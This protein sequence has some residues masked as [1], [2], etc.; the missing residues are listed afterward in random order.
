MKYIIKITLGL[1]L[2]AGVVTSCKD[3]DEP[4]IDGITVDKEEITIG[5]EG[6]TEKIAV[7]SN[8]QWVTRA[9]EPWIAI[10][11]ANGIGSAVC[12]LAI[13]STL[14]N[15]ARTAQIRFSADGRESKLVTVTQFGF[16]KQIL[17]REPEVKILSSDTYNKRHFEAII[18]TNVEFVIEEKDVEYSFAEEATMTDEE[19]EEVK[20]ECSGW[21]TLPKGKDLEVDLDRGARP[22]TIKVDF[23]WGMNVAPYTRVAKIHLVPKYPEKDQ[24][25]DSDGN[26]IDA[27]VLTVTQEKAMKIEDNR[28]GDSLA[29]ITINSKLQSMM[30]FDTSESMLNWDFVT[31]W[32][33]T[34][35]EI[36]SGELPA[37]AIGRVR[38]VSYAMIDLQ[39]GESL[40]REIRHLKYLESFTVQS[41]GN[42]QIRTISL[43]EEICGLEYLKNLTIFSVGINALPE[44]FA[45]LGKKLENLNLAN[46]NFQTLSVVTK[47]VNEDNF[48]KLRYL[49]LTG[50]RATD[51]LRDL[52]LVD[53]NNKYNGRDV[54]LHVD[55]SQ[56]QEERTALLKLLTWDKLISLELAYNFI[57]GELPTDAEMTAALADAG[58]PVSYQNTDFFSEEDLTTTPSIYLDKISSDTCQWLLTADNPVTYL[59]QSPIRGQDVPRVLP[60]AREVRLNLNFLTG[61]IP[62]WILFH[63]YFAYW[64]PIT[65]VFNQQE[66]GKN[67]AGK[68]VGFD[69]VDLVN[70]DYSYYYGKK[71]PG[72]DQVVNGVAYPLYYRK[73]VL[74][75]TID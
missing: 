36:K 26:K 7:S 71:D 27:V 62:N 2:C 41:N 72:T 6:G 42:S 29:I 8:V 22:R 69:N 11:P 66:G 43:G 30:S 33:S 10:S 46:N 44:N 56:G 53:G 58:K 37:E 48:P 59:N 63:P 9:S 1:V 31:L 35:K 55:I 19:M 39:D 32:E 74:S 75:E 5:A 12:D 18:S 70:Y 28:A 54:G 23:R 3:D 61:K 40:P 47:I 17:V 38:S 60:C 50:C 57:E 16:G 13:D 49:S 52:S 64:N 4:G 24:L 68:T 45:Q 67:T 20:G 51:T 25:V 15:T 21:L 34:D 65:L 73:F 14:M